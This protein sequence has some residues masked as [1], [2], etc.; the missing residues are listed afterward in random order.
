MLNIMFLLSFIFFIIFLLT[1][2]NFYLSMY[3]PLNREK[4]TPFECGFNAQSNSRLPF[5]TQFFL[6]TLLFLIFDIEII[7]I[8]P[9]I[10]LM[11]SKS[12]FL[13]LIMLI[14]I[15]FMIISL[16]IE[17]SYSLLNWIF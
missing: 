6:I 3:K 4:I 9:S 8:L 10:F 7:L 1:L 2:I 16:F 17:W 12:I 11:K 13:M 15:F 14:F 5:S